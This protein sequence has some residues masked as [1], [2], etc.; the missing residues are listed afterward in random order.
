MRRAAVVACVV[1]LTAALPAAV[2]A[3]IS[4]NRIARVGTDGQGLSII[5]DGGVAFQFGAAAASRAVIVAGKR[6]AVTCG[7]VTNGPGGLLASVADGHSVVRT[8][9]TSGTVLTTGIRNGGDFCALGLVKGHRRQTLVALV[10]ETRRGA[11]F[12]NQDQDVQLILDVYTLP[13]SEIAGRESE[14]LSTVD[15]TLLA[16][17]TA[18]IPAGR[19]GL[20]YKAG[21]LYIG[22]RDAAGMFIFIRRDGTKVSTDMLPF[23]TKQ[24]VPLYYGETAPLL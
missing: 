12:L 13:P 22:A 20:Y 24:Q 16:S 6:V 19:F 1:I 7:R 21:H 14:F 4:P 11:L 17:E 2:G 23:I 5:D 3:A 10:P 18:P 15:G 9:P 8:A